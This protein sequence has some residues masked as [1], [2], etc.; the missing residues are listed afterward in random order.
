MPEICLSFAK[1]SRMSLVYEMACGF[2]GGAVYNKQ[3]VLTD[4]FEYGFIGD[5][6][7]LTEP[8]EE[9]HIRMKLFNFDVFSDNNQTYT[10]QLGSDYFQGNRRLAFEV[11]LNT[12]NAAKFMPAGLLYL[13]YKLYSSNLK[14]ERPHHAVVGREYIEITGVPHL[15]R[16]D[17]VELWLIIVVIVVGVVALAGI[18]YAVYHYCTKG[19]KIYAKEKYA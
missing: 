10:M 7:A 14:S 15:R 16:W 18:S 2:N 13:E 12:V 1:T 9:W 5:K 11:D 6:I 4:G 17:G 8:P 3:A 19:K